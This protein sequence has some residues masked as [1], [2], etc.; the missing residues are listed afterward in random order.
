MFQGS[1][2][3]SSRVVPDARMSLVFIRFVVF[4]IFHA[5]LPLS[6]TIHDSLFFH[7]FLLCLRKFFDFSLFVSVNCSCLFRNHQIWALRVSFLFR[8]WVFYPFS[9]L[10]FLFLLFFLSFALHCQSFFVRFQVLLNDFH[11]NSLNSKGRDKL[12][13]VLAF[14]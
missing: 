6:Q 8:L 2:P 13:N 10:F 14:L 11:I 1:L 12:I 9:F 4:Y 3:S 7:F 5:F